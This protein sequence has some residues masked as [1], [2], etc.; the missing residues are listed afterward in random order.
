MLTLFARNVAEALPKG[1]KLL[2]EVGLEEDSRAGRVLVAPCPVMTVYDCPTERVLFSAKR[3]ANPFFHLA[4][5]LW[6]L[7]GRNDAKFLNRFVRDFGQRFAEPNGTVHGAYGFRWREH[8]GR[9]QLN[10]II[11]ILR[12][13]P[14]SRQAVLGMW[15]VNCDL[16]RPELKDRPC[17]T[18]IYFRITARRLHMTVTCRSNDIIWGAYGA[19]AVHFS[20]LQEYLAARIGVNVGT[21]YQFSNNF[22][23]YLDEL[24]KR[25]GT[26]LDARPELK[27]EPL[28]DNSTTFDQELDAMLW[29]NKLP[30]TNKFLKH[31]AYPMLK[32]HTTWR[33]KEDP[34]GWLHQIRAA[35]WRT[36]ALEWIERR[37]QNARV[38]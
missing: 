34:V 14:T 26:L 2:R 3:D 17:N 9:D 37:K 16:N 8:F 15:D 12:R 1:I 29:Q 18:Q 28:V 20:I 10:E 33:E 5:A 22:H 11:E 38:A 25:T 4:E 36:A 35:D 32:A 21:Y 24:N 7:N 23:A 31:T 13:D 19:N 27:P 6:M 30:I